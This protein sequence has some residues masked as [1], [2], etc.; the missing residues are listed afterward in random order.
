VKT[1]AP[2]IP[3]HNPIRFSEWMLCL[4]GAAILVGLALEWGAGTSGF[5]SITLLKILLIVLGLASLPIPL[6]LWLTMKSD[7]PIVWE[8]LVLTFS[9]LLA[10]TLVIK[11]ATGFV[12]E[13][14]PGF[15][16]VF[17]GCLVNTAAGWYAVSRER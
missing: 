13:A 6:V 3:L 15:W 12:S 11:T 17:G 5:Q 14:G 2:A 1:E 4:S 10:V 8:T 7:V 16:V 9:A